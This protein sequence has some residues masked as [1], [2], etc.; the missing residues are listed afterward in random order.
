MTAYAFSRAFLTAY[1]NKQGPNWWDFMDLCCKQ[2]VTL[3]IHWDAVYMFKNL[4]CNFS[5]IESKRGNNW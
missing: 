2:Q 1:Y 3:F 5:S 4:H